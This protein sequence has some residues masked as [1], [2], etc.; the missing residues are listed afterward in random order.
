MRLPL[1]EIRE[2]QALLRLLSVSSVVD[3]SQFPTNDYS[4]HC[5]L[6]L[7]V[8]SPPYCSLLT[9][10]IVLS[11]SVNDYEIIFANTAS[12]AALMAGST[13]F[14]SSESA[15]CLPE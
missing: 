2:R 1:T 10:G 12:D 3:L 7:A 15:E 5:K 11:L 4:Q 9:R 13:A 6:L 8:F 14:A